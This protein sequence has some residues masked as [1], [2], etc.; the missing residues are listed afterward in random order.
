MPPHL[1]RHANRR[2][3]QPWKQHL[4]A[5]LTQI[6]RTQRFFMQWVL[7]TWELGDKR[8][9]LSPLNLDLW[10]QAGLLW[11]SE[12]WIRIRNPSWRLRSDLYRR[13]SSSLSAFPRPHCNPLLS[14]Q[15]GS[16]RRVSFSRKRGTAGSARGFSWDIVWVRRRI[17]WKLWGFHTVF[18]WIRLYFAWH[19]DG[20]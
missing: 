8:A 12:K 19:G 14:P 16:Q 18:N 15:K 20:S 3:R 4:Q 1:N 6:H 13:P 7:F 2:V 10:L 5:E 11:H 9:M 17:F